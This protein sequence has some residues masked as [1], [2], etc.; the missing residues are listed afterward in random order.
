LV[1]QATAIRSSLVASVTDLNHVSGSLDV[2]G[3]NLLLAMIMLIAIGLSSTLF[4]ATLDENRS[5]IEGWFNRVTSRTSAVVAPL[6]RILPAPPPGSRGGRLGALGRFAAVL[7][8]T[9]LVYGFLSPDF[10]PDARSFI[11]F[12]S[13]LVGLGVVT[14]L[15]EGGSVLVSNRRLHVAAGIRIYGAAL[16]IAIGSVAISRIVDFKPGVLYGFVA[17][18]VVLAPITLGRRQRAEIVLV[19]MLLLLA[20]S[21]VAWLLLGPLRAA[22]QSE[23]SWILGLLEAVAAIVFVAA[24]ESVFF[25]M[26]PIDF[27]KGATIARWNR[28]VWAVIFGFSGF[29]FWHL[30]LNQ[31]K[32]YLQAFSQTKVIAAFAVVA[33]FCIATVVIWTYFHIGKRRTAPAD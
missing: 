23:D 9:A 18:A 14:Y 28:A 3:T 15:A 11:V 17:S 8:L 4:N 20:A 33:L 1:V 26:I 10:G 31:N 16:A 22:G 2:I 5:E 27:L 32:S 19:P 6:L 12:L 29:L 24:L 25:N 30:L 21:L 7:V 13:L